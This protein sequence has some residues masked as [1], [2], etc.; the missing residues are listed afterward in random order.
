[1]WNRS[2]RAGSGETYEENEYFEVVMQKI[3]MILTDK[4][5]KRRER[6]RERE[7]DYKRTPKWDTILS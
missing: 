5:L 1:M 6:E 3:Y 4:V 2:I 7:R